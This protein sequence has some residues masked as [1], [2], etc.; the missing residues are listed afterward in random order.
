MTDTPSKLEQYCMGCWPSIIR[1]I[2]PSA[3]ETSARTGHRLSSFADGSDCPTIGPDGEYCRCIGQ[4]L[5]IMIPSVPSDIALNKHEQSHLERVEK[6][7]KG[8]KTNQ[9]RLVRRTFQPL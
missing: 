3:L 7:H 1:Q 6:Q 2:P 8:P 9:A 4:A 5:Y